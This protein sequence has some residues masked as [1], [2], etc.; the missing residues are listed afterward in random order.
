MWPRLKVDILIS[1]YSTMY[2]INV[3]R[4]I[5]DWMFFICRMGMTIFALSLKERPPSTLWVPSAVQICR[6]PNRYKKQRLL[7]L[8]WKAKEGS[9]KYDVIIIRKRILL[10]LD[11]SSRW[12]DERD[13]VARGTFVVRIL[14]LLLLFAIKALQLNRVSGCGW[15]PS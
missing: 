15:R 2:C 1:L 7:L 11:I 12:Q 4:W 6:P 9:E 13:F 5:P 8:L 10:L 3:D 14:L